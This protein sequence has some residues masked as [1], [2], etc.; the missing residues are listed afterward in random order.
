VKIS[1]PSWR[2]TATS[3]ISAASA[4]RT[5]SAVGAETATA[6]GTPMAAAFSIAFRREAVETRAAIHQ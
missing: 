1:K 3:V 2:A 5:A 4:I 6:S